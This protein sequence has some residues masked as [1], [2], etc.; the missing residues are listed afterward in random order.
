MAQKNNAIIDIQDIKAVLR[1]FSK[2]WYILV[3]LVA[4]AFVISQVYLYKIPDVYSAET[5]ILLK[6]D[7]FDSK[8]L[9][10]SEGAGGYYGS[11]QTYVDNTNELRV[12]Q[13]YDLIQKAV[14]RMNLGISYFI[15]GRFASREMYDGSPFKIQVG[16]INSGLYENMMHFKILNVHQYQITYTEGDQ[17]Q[18]FVGTF[19][20]FSVNSDMKL[21]VT[22]SP[23]VNRNTIRSLENSDYTIKIHNPKNL[24]YRYRGALSVAIIDYTNILQVSLRDNVPERAIAFLDT[25]AEVYME[26]SLKSKI[27][28]N[29]NTLF[30]IDKQMAEVST[31]LD[32]VQNDLQHYKENK[33]ILDLGKE[34]D[35]YFTKLSDFDKTKSMLQM[36]IGA[37]DA[38]EKYIIENKD[39]EF[40]PPAVYIVS[41]D[42][43]LKK[44][45]D[46][47]YSMQISINSTLTD[48]TEKNQNIRNA[49]EKIKLLKNNLLIYIGNSRV[50]LNSQIKD[51]NGQVDAYV[52]SIKTIPA[53]QRGLVDIERNM[54]VNENMY[55]FLLQ[56]RANTTIAQAT[57][58]PETEVIETARSMGV[59]APQKSKISY[60]FMGVGAIIS[61]IIIFIR[62]VFFEKIESIEELKEKTDLPILGEILFD[63][64]VKDILVT[65]ENNPKSPIIESFRTIR[66]NLQYMDTEGG[67]KVILITSNVPGEGKTFCS[68][69][70]AT[71]LAKSERKVL[72]LELDLHKPRV[73]KALN[74]SSEIGISTIIIGKN[75]IQECILK[76]SI[77]NLD[78]LLSGPLPPNAS[79]LILSKRMN[80]IFE[81]GKAHYDYIIIDTPPVGLISDALALMKYANVNL[82]V[83]NTKSAYK[84]SIANAHEIV[85][86][87]KINN[88]GIVLNGVKR[89]KSKYYYNRY[90]YGYGYGYGYGGNYGYGDKK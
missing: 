17:E 51:V 68:V 70:L 75:T 18:K 23:Q 33:N 60:M 41:N 40:L 37:L 20:E 87:N 64:S 85:T 42:A 61:L 11:G 31:I 90:A 50:A 16:N 26:N 53:K 14:D 57:I 5:E 38:L 8:N 27:K 81:Y 24:V 4:A 22:K 3:C 54:Q 45:V 86:N 13:S 73:H 52:S 21:L 65:V 19:D 9:I 66:T 34:E 10:S 59:V 63:Q 56:K 36:Q 84:E 76:S 82:Y 55:E 58:I 67:S 47:L 25:L 28:I 35:D 49:N 89:K 74:M 48:A 12:L 32:S 72:L 80:E 83:I 39:P 29:A 79:E 15:V 44:S 71:I 69:N 46:E 30:Y 1:I 43:F 77:D 6:N 7:N 2:N 78:V 62:T 88:L